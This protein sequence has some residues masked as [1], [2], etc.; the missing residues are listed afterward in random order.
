IGVFDAT[1]LVA[2]S[3]FNREELVGALLL[4]RLLYYIIPFVLSLGLVAWREFVMRPRATAAKPRR[5][6]STAACFYLRPGI[7]P[8]GIHTGFRPGGGVSC[9]MSCGA[10]SSSVTSNI[11]CRLPSTTPL[12]RSMIPSRV[13]QTSVSIF[14]SSAVFASGFH[15]SQ[16]SPATLSDPTRWPAPVAT[17]ALLWSPAPV[18]IAIGAMPGTDMIIMPF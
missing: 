9:L 17:P 4:F 10:R 14:F 3:Q 1:M 2:L 13:T 18:S 16:V 15:R 7:A 11:V 12:M 6:P 5:R 8:V